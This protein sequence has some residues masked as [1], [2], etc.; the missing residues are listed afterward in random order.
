MVDDESVTGRICP[1]K[2]PPFRAQSYPMSKTRRKTLTQAFSTLNL[3]FPPR[4]DTFCS[5]YMYSSS[6]PL[7]IRYH[8]KKRECNDTTSYHASHFNFG[9]GREFVRPPEPGPRPRSGPGIR[10]PNHPPLLPTPTPLIK[11]TPQIL[12]SRIRKP[13]PGQLRPDPTPTPRAAPDSAS[14]VMSAPVGGR[15]CP[16]AA[17]HG[18]CPTP[19]TT[20]GDQPARLG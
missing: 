3:R 4:H 11:P 13:E 19:A 5:T 7:P 1:P 10:I 20:P 16:S 15:P 17:W 18:I 9:G 6:P 12:Q 14:K 2:R 8:A